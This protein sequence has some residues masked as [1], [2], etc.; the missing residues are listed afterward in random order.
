MSPEIKWEGLKEVIADKM[1]EEVYKNG[2]VVFKERSKING[3]ENYSGMKT[4]WGKKK[5]ELKW[6]VQ[7]TGKI[8][9]WNL[10]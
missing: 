9:R 5:L 3:G 4:V 2:I 8:G 1:E 7:E 10:L 6:V